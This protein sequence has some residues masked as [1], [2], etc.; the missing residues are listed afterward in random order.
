MFLPRQRLARSNRIHS[1]S[2]KTLPDEPSG[3]WA[4]QHQS[5]STRRA[6]RNRMN[7]QRLVLALSLTIP[8]ILHAQDI[9]VRVDPSPTPQPA[10]RQSLLDLD[11][12]GSGP[13]YIA[14]LAKFKALI[15]Q[16]GWPTVSTAGRDGVDAA[17]DLTR[18]SSTDYN[19]QNALEAAMQSRLGTDIDV[20]AFAVLNDHIEQ[21]HDNTQQLGSL[22]TLQ[23]GK[24]VTSPYISAAEANPL[25]D[26]FGLLPLDLYLKQVQTRVDAGASLASAMQVP[27]LSTELHVLTQP[28]L[29]AEL[30]AMAK[31]DQAVREA[32]I[33]GGLKVGSP[34]QQR[35]REIDAKNLLRLRTIFHQY[36]F[37]DASLV[38][39]GG[40]EDFWLLI[41]HAT[42]DIPLMGKAVDLARPLMLKGDL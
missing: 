21:A 1:W 6:A 20:R 5:R 15:T 4:G 23:D 16:Y 24:V 18:R 2:R 36:G 25:R 37:P 11:Q 28:A 30:K 17:G 14:T 35:M 26:Q 33:R 29:H 34:E 13:L 19:Y 42:T 32:F 27:R 12:Q 40:V 31:E 7:P 41:Q 38:G 10:L 9:K 3:H 22:L 39:R 8:F